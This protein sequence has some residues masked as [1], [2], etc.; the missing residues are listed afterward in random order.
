VGNS[1]AIFTT[2]TTGTY[3]GILFFD[4]RTAPA[5]NPDVYGGGATAVYQ[6]VIYD[7]NNGI[8]MHGNSS[9]NTQYTLVIADTISLV[10]TTAFNDNY[11]TL[12]NGSPIQQV[13]VVE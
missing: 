8:T 1:S 4:D 2:P 13:M 6:G 9:V 7:K 10:G 11:S 12:P 5:N 3:A